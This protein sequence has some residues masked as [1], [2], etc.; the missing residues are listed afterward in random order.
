MPKSS[1]V[2]SNKCCHE[3]IVLIKHRH[4]GRGILYGFFS[5][6]QLYQNRIIYNTLSKYYKHETI[7]FNNTIILHNIKCV[8][9]GI[10]RFLF[11]Q[12]VLFY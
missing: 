3:I 10:Y 4:C 2:F 12:H 5:P 1:Q 7:L 6:F 9:S 11:I 8:H